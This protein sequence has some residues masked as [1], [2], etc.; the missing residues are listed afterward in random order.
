MKILKTI[1]LLAVTVSV[2]GSCNSYEKLLKSNDYAKKYNVAMEYFEKGNY[3]KAIQLFENL[4]M[5]YRGKDNDENIVWYHAESYLKLKDYYNAGYHYGMFIRKYPYSERVEEAYF[6]SAYCKY[7]ESPVYSLDQTQTKEAIKDFEIY[8]ERYP[9][10]KHIPEIN[11]YLDEMRY[12]LMKKDYE[13]AYGYYKIGA[14]NA[15]YVAFNDFINQYPDSE[16]R[17]NAMFY[18]IKAG[19]E[20]AINSTESK[21]VQR[22]QQVIND[23]DRF[24]TLFANSKHISESQDIYNKTRAALQVRT[25]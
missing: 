9:T 23:F 18:I 5:Y 12:K 7:M 25:K 15:A 2:L 3:S 24:A 10:S 11:K 6:M 14:Y 19:Y 22:L 17:E 13:I 1:L 8:V 16:Q 4:T 21:I 20:Y